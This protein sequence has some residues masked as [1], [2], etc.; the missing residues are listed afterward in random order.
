MTSLFN[1]QRVLVWKGRYN[2]TKTNIWKMCFFSYSN[3]RIEKV[4]ITLSSF[5]YAEEYNVISKPT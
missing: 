4:E 1:F 5:K 2:W 3:T